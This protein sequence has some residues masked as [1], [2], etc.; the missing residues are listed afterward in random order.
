MRTLICLLL[1]APTLAVAGE[2]PKDAIVGPA[3]Q[4]RALGNLTLYPLLAKQP[5]PDPGYMTLDEA[6]KAELLTVD[7]TDD[8]GTVNTLHVK[9]RAKRPIYALAGEVLLG[10]KQDRIIG[11]HTL[12]PAG[13]VDLAIGVFCVEHGR[14]SGGTPGKFASGNALAH[15]KLRQQANRGSQ[16]AV[17]AEVQQKNEQR[18]TANGTDTYRAALAQGDYQQ[19]TKVALAEILRNTSGIADLAGIA[20]AVNGEMRGADWFAAPAL[21]RKLEGKLLRSYIAE[22]LDAADG[23][24]HAAPAPAV[25][26]AFVAE[27]DREAPQAAGESGAAALYNY[28]NAEIEGQMT[29]PKGAGKAVHRSIYKKK[30]GDLA[31]PAGGGEMNDPHY[32]RRQQRR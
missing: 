16:S 23:V 5:E 29:T 26:N 32:E 24:A 22:A 10:G 1:I 2:L 18:A 11:Q 27:V 20:V 14:W 30:A 15:T 31:A 25:A 28:D 21:Y 3:I 12:I 9:S 6:I 13:A 4:V 19:R 7:E 8:S 17:W